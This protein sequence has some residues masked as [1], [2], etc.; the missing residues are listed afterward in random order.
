MLLEAG[1]GY[2]ESTLFQFFIKILYSAL[3][4]LLGPN[5]PVIS[6]SQVYIQITH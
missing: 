4:C 3:L 6:D 5:F 2:E 1:I